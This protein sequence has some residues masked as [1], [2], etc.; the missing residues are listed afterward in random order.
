VNESTMTLAAADGLPLFVYHWPC[1]SP[2][3]IVQI[4]HG[5]AEHAARYRWT[6]QQLCDAGY[7]VYANDHRGHGN[8]ASTEDLGYFAEEDGWN[9]MVDD[10]LQLN[11]H[12]RRCHPSLPLVLLGHSMGSFL[13]QQYLIEHGETID[14]VVLSGSTVADGYA[15]LAPLLEQELAALGRRAASQVMRQVSA[16][17]MGD[18]VPDAKTDWDWLSRDEQQVA[19]YIADPL[20]GFELRLGSILDMI[21]AMQIT[22]DPEQLKR[23]RA[24][25]PMYLFAGSSDPL[26]NKLQS[27]H[28]LMERYAQAG[29]K[30]ISHHFYEGGRHEMLNELNRDEVVADLLTWLRRS[31]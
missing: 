17:S 4:A 25:L 20:C 1:A 12:I 16:A 21:A 8:T 2:R 19:A 31:L 10:L 3:G 23:I 15:G 28:L 9:K 26:N 13:A 18:S 24:Q 6:A 27:L 5:A 7:A 11:R 29:L 22:T 30:D 14:A